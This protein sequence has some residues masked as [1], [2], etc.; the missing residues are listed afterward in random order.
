LGIDPGIEALAA[1]FNRSIGAFFYAARA[2]KAVVAEPYEGVERTFE[3]VAE[4][5]DRRRPPWRYEVFEQCE[6]QV[7]ELIGAEWP[8]RSGKSS[9]RCGAR[10]WTNSPLA[11]CR[12]V[13]ARSEDG[14]TPTRD[15]LGWHGAWLGTGAPMP[16]SKPGWR[17]ALPHVYC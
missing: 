5:R 8:W 4:F 3:R 15:S 2:G 9:A 1:G 13:V 7:H 16:S 17:A 11:A 10:A 12:S 14:T 6:E